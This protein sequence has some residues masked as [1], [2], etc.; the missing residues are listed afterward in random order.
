MRSV[1]AS[2]ACVMDIVVK[3]ALGTGSERLTAL[4]NEHKI[5]CPMKKSGVMASIV[6]PLGLFDDV[7]GDAICGPSA[8][9]QA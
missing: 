4:R 3:F 5:Y 6:T 7:E 2:S 9:C 8:C 1:G